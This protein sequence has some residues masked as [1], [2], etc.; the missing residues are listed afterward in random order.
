MTLSSAP[1]QTLEILYSYVDLGLAI[2]PIWGVK[3]GKCRCPKGAAC[4]SSPGKHPIARLVP[5]GVKNATRDKSVIAHWYRNNAGLNWAVRCGEPLASGG[6]LLVLDVDPRNGGNATFAA[7]P[8]LPETARQDTGGGGV[9]YFFKSKDP[10]FS[11]SCGPGLDLQAAGKYVLVDPSLHVSGGTYSWAMGAELSGTGIAYA[12]E[13]LLEPDGKTAARPPREGDG[14]ARDT[15]LGEAFALAGML[16]VS[17]PD[18]NVAVKCP[19]AHEHSDGRGRGQDSSTVILPPAGGSL[20]GGFRCLHGHCT[21]RKYHDV[22]KALPA[23]AV[24]AAN[25]KYPM[26]PVDA[27]PAEPERPTPTTGADPLD[28]VR[29]K[30]SYKQS[31]A[32]YK[33]IGDVVN[34]T[35]ILIYDH[36]WAGVLQFDEFAQRLR[37]ARP[38]PWHADDRPKVQETEWTDSDTVR[39]EAW[40]RRYWGFEISGDK[41]REVVFAVGMRNSTNPLQDWLRGL[42]WDGVARLDDWLSTYLGCE[43]TPYT[44]SC[45]PKWLLSAV[46]R[47]LRRGSKADTVLILEGP[48]GQFKSSA[49]RTLCPVSDWFTDTPFDLGSKDAYLA[50]QGRWIIEL[51]ELATLNRSDAGKAKAFFSSPD[52][53]FRPPYGRATIR[54]P[55]A[56]VFAGSV[57]EG[58]YLRDE[59][60]N[61]RYWPVRVGVIDL[62]GL[63]RDRDQIW[64]EAASRYQLWVGRG[65]PVSECLWWPHPDERKLFETEQAE[66]ELPEIWEET[67]A[68]WIDSEEAMQLYKTH[69]GLVV[70]DIL[71]RALKIKPADQTRAEQ[72]RIGVAMQR[73]KWRRVRGSI[74]AARVSLYKRSADV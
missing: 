73:L 33:V 18:G 61:R 74:G 58:E 1:D 72:T 66:R 20:F 37:F 57:N 30:L 47:G 50:L 29:K 5:N 21:N 43:S 52:D 46:A 19:W 9:H 7:A 48:Q 17:L 2:L 15:V 65:S 67:L 32:G 16:G 10:P 23:S 54:V 68:V 28:E 13:W 11:R 69:R 42:Q 4:N 24:D 12:P 39:L 60:G 70:S 8:G 64:A 25:R 31:G 49:L 63:A 71:E 59:T 38:P 56:C 44:R 36:R 41:I 35:T 6:Y 53:T 3:G 27:G 40:L 26:R 14:S 51:Q 55:R 62:E 22:L 34:L 45:G